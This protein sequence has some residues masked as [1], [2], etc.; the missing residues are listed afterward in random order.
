[1]GK[2][3]LEIDEIRPF[4]SCSLPKVHSKG[5]QNHAIR[6]LDS[7]MFRMM[8]FRS[9]VK[10]C[11]K[12]A[13]RRMPAGDGELALNLDRP[14]RHFISGPKGLDVTPRPMGFVPFEPLMPT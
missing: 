10:K 1:L 12:P 8:T 13:M 9:L 6:M 4:A 14:T 2:F 3:K 5:K 7:S 11:L